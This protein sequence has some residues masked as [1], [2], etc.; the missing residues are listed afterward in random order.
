MTRGS[1]HSFHFVLVK[2]MRYN[3]FHLYTF[4]LPKGLIATSIYI[5][6]I[7]HITPS[8]KIKFE[9][10]VRIVFLLYK[11]FRAYLVISLGTGGIVNIKPKMALVVK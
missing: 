6:K 5:D 3:I 11:R 2:N 10:L 7:G 8:Y 9:K 4:I 1:D